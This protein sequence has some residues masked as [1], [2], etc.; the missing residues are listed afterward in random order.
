MRQKH[1]A[2]LVAGLETWMR[3]ARAKMSRHADVAKAMDYMLKRWG[4]FSRFTADGRICLT[5]NAA[6]QPRLP[7]QGDDTFIVPLLLKYLQTLEA[8]SAVR[9][10]TG[11]FA[12]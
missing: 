10:D 7:S 6:E 5:N 12:V 1:I 8:H 3:A 9:C 2:P 4:T 11:G